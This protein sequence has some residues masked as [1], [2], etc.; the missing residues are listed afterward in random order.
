MA[1][2]TS[3]SLSLSGGSVD[4]TT[5]LVFKIS[6]CRDRTAQGSVNSLTWS[7]V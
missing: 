7:C 2:A 1:L 6:F 4:T 5:V 3:Q